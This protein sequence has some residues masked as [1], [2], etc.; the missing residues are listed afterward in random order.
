MSTFHKT[1]DSSLRHAHPLKKLI[2]VVAIKENTKQ[3]EEV[4]LT[5]AKI[6]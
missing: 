5:M 3:I 1:H 2:L 6:L 4:Q